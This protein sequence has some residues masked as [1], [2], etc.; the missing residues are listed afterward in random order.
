M[1]HKGAEQWNRNF[2][3]EE[4]VSRMIRRRV[5]GWELVVYSAIEIGPLR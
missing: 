1:R 3:G 5:H 2:Q 4:G